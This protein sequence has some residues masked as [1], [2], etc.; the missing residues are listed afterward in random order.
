MLKLGLKLG[1]SCE[2]MRDAQVNDEGIEQ[3]IAKQAFFNA[4]DIHTVFMSPMRR[5]IQT[6]YYTFKDH[7]N[8]ENIKFIVVP[9]WREFMNYASGVPSNIQETVKSFEGKLPNIDMSLFDEFEDKLHY[10]LY[11]TDPNIKEEI[12]KKLAEKE[13]DWIGSNAFDLLIDKSFS[14]KPKRLES[15][16]S[17]LKRVN[18][19]KAYIREYVKQLKDDQKVV[20]VS[21]FFFLRTWTG[22]WDTGFYDEEFNDLR[23][24]D[25]AMFFHNTDA[26]YDNIE[27][28]E[29]AVIQL[30]LERAQQSQS[31][32]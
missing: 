24:P 30:E 1:Y 12:M 13:G 23:R 31:D 8:L 9:A 20:I 6:A 26:C 3:C 27:D 32:V 10:F 5:A 19:V 2:S 25:R 18:K 11:D 22:K 14:V 21:H 29:D 15:N 7:P 28:S 17:I 4:I 16:L